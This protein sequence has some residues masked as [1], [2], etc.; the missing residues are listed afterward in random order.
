MKKIAFLGT[1]NMGAG[2]ASRLVSAGYE[3]HIYNRTLKKMDS[4][5]KKG[6]IIC[7]SP[8]EAA[9]EA[10]AVFSMVGDDEASKAMW[11]GEEGA[12][13]ATIPKD[14]FIIE[15][16]T[17]THSWVIELAK[18]AKSKNL[19]YIDCPVTGIPTTASSGELTLFVGAQESDLKK[20]QPLLNNLSK[21][22][23]HFGDVGTGTTYKLMVNLI[24]A[25]QIASAAEGML[26]AEKAGLNAETVAYALSRGAAASPQV[27]RTTNK[28]AKAEHTK[29]ITFSGKLRLKDIVYALALT[30]TLG[31][32]T[33]F[34]NKARH[35]FQL[36]IDAG[37]ENLSETKVID[38]L[39]SRNSN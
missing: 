37:M 36:L 7:K 13:A 10:E 5:A 26:I 24:G 19:C 29:N 30:E 28:M 16:S 18:I 39:R 33:L 3:V 11:L 12:L 32:K 20:V 14:A 15:C 21:E 4:L 31:Q 35:A 27:I 22:T 25:V 8:K 6:A 1:G 17:L 38:V 2:M 23:I 34:G 9:K